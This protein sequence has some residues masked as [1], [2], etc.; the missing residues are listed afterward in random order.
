MLW[1]LVL[2]TSAATLVVALVLD[3]QPGEPEAESCPAWLHAL[4]RWGTGIWAL[5]VAVM[6]ILWLLLTAYLPAGALVGG[7]C[8]ALAW[9]LRG[10]PDADSALVRM[11]RIARPAFWMQTLV[12][13]IAAGT[14]ITAALDPPLIAIASGWSLDLWLAGCL[15]GALLIE[16]VGR[17]W[18]H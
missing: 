10:A 18:N 11:Q 5:L 9:G 4:M 17:I 7:T 12:V 13:L 14:L 2:A 3:P 15:F 16:L 8:L 6:G 1:M